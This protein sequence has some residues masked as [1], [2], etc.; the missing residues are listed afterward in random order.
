MQ[1]FKKGL[2][3]TGQIMTTIVFNSNVIAALLVSPFLLMNSPRIIA[4][5]IVPEFIQS[6]DTSQFTPPSP[7]PAGIVYLPLEKMFLI[8]DSEVNETDLFKEVNVFKINRLGDLVAT[9]STTSFSDEPTGVTINPVNK[10][11][12]L[13]DDDD[14]SIYE[15]NPGADLTC[16][17]GDDTVTSFATDPFEIYD[18]EDVTFGLGSLFI[19]D[20]IAEQVYRFIPGDNGFNQRYSSF[21]TEILGMHDPEGIVFDSTNESLYIAG[22]NT[23]LIIHT[24]TYG[25][26]LDTLNITGI[27]ATHDTNRTVGK[28]AG[29]ALAPTSRDETRTSLYMVDRGIDNNEELAENDG[30]IWELMLPVTTPG[31]IKPMVV[32]GNYQSITR[33]DSALLYGL[34]IDDGSLGSSW[35]STW[36]KLSGPGEVSFTD[37]NN[38]KT[39]ASFTKGG[40]YVLRLTAYD[41][42]LYSFDDIEITVESAPVLTLKGDNP[43]KLKLG[44][45]FRDPGA[46]ALDDT[47]GDLTDK[48]IVTGNVNTDVAATYT[49]T[50]TVSDSAYNSV[51]ASRSVVIK[52][53]KS[54]KSKKEDSN[55]IDQKDSKDKK[56]NK[57]NKDKKDKH[58]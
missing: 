40:T 54:K 51:S 5:E 50:Y 16:F 3:S 41:G 12:F 18:P 45:K 22:S 53:G 7:D 47:D 34:V 26:L 43:M 32:A 27:T 17:T 48:I 2:R 23:G 21:D 1:T 13:S 4:A 28:P 57:G 55:R 30:M 39:N 37:P 8:T 58:H 9:Y 14:K 42:E 31:N 6:I 38:I 56:D 44:A 52:G 10:H 29:L 15:I 20:G 46:T 19:V 24:T 35:F 36:S 25:V 11:C 49:I 33:P